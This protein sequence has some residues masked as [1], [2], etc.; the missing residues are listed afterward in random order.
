MVRSS[1]KRVTNERRITDQRRLNG[2]RRLVD[3]GAPER[4]WGLER[5]KKE[6]GP[7]ERRVR[8]DRRDNEAGPPT[9]WRERRRWA[10]RRR[11]DVV[12]TSF[13]EWVRLRALRCSPVSEVNSRPEEDDKLGGLIIR[14]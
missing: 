3:A 2:D 10:E 12:E 8:H 6:L 4:R 14:D 7:P 9:G 11:P 5:R 13:E 1:S